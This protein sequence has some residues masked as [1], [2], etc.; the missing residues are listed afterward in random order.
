MYLYRFL[1]HNFLSSSLYI[2]KYLRR[3]SDRTV[4]NIFKNRY[5]HCGYLI[6]LFNRCVLQK[7]E[8]KLTPHFGAPVLAS[9]IARWPFF[10][11]PFDI[12]LI[13]YGM[14]PEHLVFV[15][16]LHTPVVVSHVLE[17]LSVHELFL[18]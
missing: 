12:E 5:K 16:H 6:I 8:D 4:N 17:S 2:H 10:S 15:L 9:A 18:H 11:V 13:Q 3:W 7:R 1:G 14:V